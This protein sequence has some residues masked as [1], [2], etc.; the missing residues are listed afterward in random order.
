MKKLDRLN[1]I[2][3]RWFRKQLSVCVFDM[4][5]ERLTDSSSFV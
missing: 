5:V 3:C 2:S 4:V 1:E